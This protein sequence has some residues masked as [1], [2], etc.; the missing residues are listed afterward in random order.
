LIEAG[1][2][3]GRPDDAAAALERL[4]ERTQASGTDGARGSKRAAVR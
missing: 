4:S 3:S 2:R 1:V